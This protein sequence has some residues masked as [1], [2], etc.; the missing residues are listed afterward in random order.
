ML[1]MTLH[2]TPSSRLWTFQPLGFEVFQVLLQ[3]S[4]FN[5]F[6]GD[7]QSRDFRPVEDKVHFSILC[8]NI[9]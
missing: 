3:K 1:Q 6:F 5:R 8:G 4:H 9:Y 2:L 7:I